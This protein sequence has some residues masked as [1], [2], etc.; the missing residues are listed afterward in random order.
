MD[1]PTS[2]DVRAWAPPLFTW[3][4]YGY[5]APASGDSDLLD[6][7]VA[8]AVADLHV[9]CDRTLESIT[10]VEERTA[11][12]VIVG[13]VMHTVTAGGKKALKALEDR[14]SRR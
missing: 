14:A 8:D 7:R 12:Q 4:T 13:I 2:A 5:P 6:E 9:Y 11:Q 1:S 3:S 10:S